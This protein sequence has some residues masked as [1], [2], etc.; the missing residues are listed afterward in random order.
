[1]HTDQLAVMNSAAPERTPLPRRDYTM[2]LLRRAAL[3]ET[4]PMPRLEALREAI[5]KAAAERAQSYI[6]SA[7]GTV[8]RTQ[9][10]RFYQSVLCQLDAALLRMESDAQAEAAL[11]DA[12]IPQL[13]Q[14]G[15]QCTIEDFEN[16]KARYRAARPMM[17]RYETIFTKELLTEFSQFI[18]QYDARYRAADTG[19]HVLYPLATGEQITEN[20]AAGVCRYYTALWA[21]SQILAQIPEDE[22]HAMLKGYA[23]KYRTDTGNIAENLAELA[24]RHWFLAALAQDPSVCTVRVTQADADT[25]QTRFGSRPAEQLLRAME[26]TVRMSPFAELETADGIAPADYLLR[27]VPF[28]GGQLYAALERG[29]LASWA[30]I[31]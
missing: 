15:M 22:M 29:S 25:V 14:L 18:T 6:G 4:I 28:I 30:V 9:A 1:M 24:L 17:K 23:D 3:E 2:E 19:V 20:G 12:P 7:T 5:H 26:Q 10:E 21:E 11:R 16:A 27:T 8:S 13:M 31:V